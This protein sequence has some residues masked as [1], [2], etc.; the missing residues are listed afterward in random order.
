MY[1]G[2]L[3]DSEK[4]QIFQQTILADFS[5]VM[6]TQSVIETECLNYRYV[7]HNDVSVNDGPPT[8]NP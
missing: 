4:E 3:Y 2:I 8:R 1:L 6:E 5:F 7:P